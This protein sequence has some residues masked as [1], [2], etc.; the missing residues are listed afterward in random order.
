MN[1]SSP[2]PNHRGRRRP[3]DNPLLWWLLPLLRF[4]DQ[5]PELVALLLLLATIGLGVAMFVSMG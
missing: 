4:A 2:E 5:R 3:V 1:N